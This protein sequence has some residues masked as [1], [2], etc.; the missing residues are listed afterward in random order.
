MNYKIIFRY[1]PVGGKEFIRDFIIS[2]ID[3]NELNFDDFEEF[4]KY[5][6]YLIDSP[7]FELTIKEEDFYITDSND[8]LDLDTNTHIC[9]IH[10]MNVGDDDLDDEIDD[11]E[12]IF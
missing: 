2:N 3:N 11:I 4:I 7:N 8:I 12:T 10:L 9:N 1:S 5:K 6:D